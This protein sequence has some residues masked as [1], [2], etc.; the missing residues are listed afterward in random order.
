[1][2]EARQPI[3]FLDVCNQKFS[4]FLFNAEHKCLVWLR[5]I[6]EEAMKIFDSNNFS[7]EPEL[8]PKTPSQKK[9]RK[10]KRSSLFKDENKEL[11]RKRLSRGHGSVK[12]ASFQKL[13]PR[14]GLNNHDVRD[15]IS[16]PDIMTNSSKGSSEV[17]YKIAVDPGEE[18]F[19]IGCCKN[20]EVGEKRNKDM[21]GIPKIFTVHSDDH[22]VDG[23]RITDIAIMSDNPVMVVPDTTDSIKAEKNRDASSLQSISTPK[24]FP[25]GKHKC[26]EEIPPQ[27]LVNNNLDPE[28]E[29]SQNLKES[30]G[31]STGP[32]SGHRPLSRPHKNP[33][34]SLVEKYSL[35]N[36]RKSTIRKSISRTIARKQVAQDS[37]STSSRVSC[38]SSTEVFMDDENSKHRPLTQNAELGESLNNLQ[39]EPGVLDASSLIVSTPVHN[40]AQL[41]RRQEKTYSKD[42]LETKITDTHISNS[43]DL[44]RNNSPYEQMQ[45]IR[46][47]SYN[48]AVEDLPAPSCTKDKNPSPS[49]H[50]TTSTSA[51]KILSTSGPSKIIQPFR[52]FFQ[53]MQKNQ[54]LRSPGS[55]GNNVPKHSTP[56]R[57]A[58]KGEFVEKE[59]QRLES[60]RKKQEAEQQRKQKVEEEKRRRLEEIKLKREE[61]LRKALQ[62]RERVEQM[63]EEKKKRMEQK[64]SQFDERNDKMREEKTAE[65]KAKKKISIKKMEAEVRKQKLLQTEEGPKLQERPEKWRTIGEIKKMLEYN[66][67]RQEKG[68]HKQQDKEKLVKVQELTIVKEEEENLKEEKNSAPLAQLQQDKTAVQV[69]DVPAACKWL[70]IT[71]Q[72]SYIG[73]TNQVNAQDLKDTKSLKVSLN[74]YGMDLNS[75][76]ST[77]DES[78]PRKPIPLWANGLQLNEAV[79]YQYY[80]PPDINRL[81]GLILSPKLEDIFYKS[82]PRYFKRTS[83]AVWQSPPLPGSKPALRT[84]NS[85]KKY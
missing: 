31:A 55:S 58:S 82:K 51:K 25:N 15:T 49:N 41:E 36:K 24:T 71:A 12:T 54:L 42:R 76:D 47:Q 50:K 9:Y 80:N 19:G 20:G 67:T 40:P 48:Q 39:K 33:R 62:A 44:A 72:K 52:N 22:L 6:E 29:L 78:Q 53:T 32:L 74:D 81:F 85:M 26:E 16:L 56:N 34:I 17:Q 70:N 11:I 79:T 46:K 4:E 83:S 75:D 35:S 7:T 64:F 8:M 5:E 84:S 10:K 30:T 18:P 59:R 57:S 60:L 13:S 73:S 1:M 38:H 66:S 28:G 69:E 61:R 37:S 45:N 27:E 3:H 2:A 14:R 21:H 63:E 68:H 77:D 43:E 23:S 65:E